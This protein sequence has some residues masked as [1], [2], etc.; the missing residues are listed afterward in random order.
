MRTDE[1]IS[2]IN[3]AAGPHLII[4]E[5]RPGLLTFAGFFITIGVYLFGL[6]PRLQVTRWS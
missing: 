6:R 4:S 5:N 2:L 3:E 1:R